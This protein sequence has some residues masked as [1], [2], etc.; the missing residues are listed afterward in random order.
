MAM[1]PPRNKQEQAELDAIN[2]LGKQCVDL[3]L[4]YDPIIMCNVAACLLV[5]AIKGAELT[6][7]AAHDCV[8]S[9]W[10]NKN[11]GAVARIGVKPS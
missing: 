4:G 8:D 1:T 10:D 7:E 3:F 2:T 6:L 9:Y 5:G 11:G